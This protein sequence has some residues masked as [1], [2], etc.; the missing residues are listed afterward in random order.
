MSTLHTEEIFRATCKAVWHRGYR[1]CRHKMLSIIG[2]HL[3]GPISLGQGLDH[4]AVRRLFNALRNAPIEHP[5]VQN[6]YSSGSGGRIPSDVSRVL[7]LTESPE[8][9][10]TP[11]KDDEG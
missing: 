11:G 4:E 2:R 5:A 6:P 1:S 7:N 10:P 9:L 8:G 3:A